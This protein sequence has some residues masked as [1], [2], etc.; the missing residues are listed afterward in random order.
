MLVVKS[1]LQKDSGLLK[2][3]LDVMG[4]PPASAAS[5]LPRVKGTPVWATQ[6]DLVSG[7]GCCPLN[8][9][10]WVHLVLPEYLQWMKKPSPTGLAASKV[11][12]CAQQQEACLREEHLS[13]PVAA[14]CCSQCPEEEDMAGKEHL[15]FWLHVCR[16]RCSATWAWLGGWA[17][18]SGRS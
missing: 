18:C 17:L 13:C 7:A 4:L 9:C 3:Q 15:S 1:T 2:S 16:A 6:L 11:H 14:C 12:L 8:E 5:V 10:F